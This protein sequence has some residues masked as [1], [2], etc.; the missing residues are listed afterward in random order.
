MPAHCRI[1]C[2]LDARIPALVVE[3]G[4]RGVEGEHWFRMYL[5]SREGDFDIWAPT[6][7]EA[8]EYPEVGDFVAFRIVRFATELPEHAS[9]IGYIDCRLKP[10]LNS[11][12]GWHISSTF[13]PDNLKPELHLG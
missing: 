1:R 12:K 5:A 3:E 11:R 7:A 4:R 6:L 13:R 2:F 9:L 10:V 8:P